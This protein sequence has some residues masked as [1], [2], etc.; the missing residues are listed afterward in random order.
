MEFGG[1]F[2]SE[3]CLERISSFNGYDSLDTVILYKKKGTPEQH[4]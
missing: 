2:I 3:L 1:I 4:P